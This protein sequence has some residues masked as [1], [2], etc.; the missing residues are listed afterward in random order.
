[1]TI[2]GQ[3]APDL[4]PEAYRTL[5]LERS[6]SL[7]DHDPGTRARALIAM[8]SRYVPRSPA[9]RVLCVGC[10]NARELDHLA[11]AGYPGAT[12]IDLHSA[13]PRVLVMDMHATS[14][15]DASFDVVYASHAL[16]HALDP[17]RAAAEFL[18]VVR[19]GGWIVIEVPVRYGRRGADLWDFGSPSVVASLFPGAAVLWSDVAP[20]IG[21]EKQLAARLIL[22][23]RANDAE[24]AS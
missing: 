5:Q 10:R 13:D 2:T 11:A 23:A 20:Q 3:T 9:P 12:G 19:G 18:R 4:T 21:A 15:E 16:E 1:M 6:L 24:G 14:F 17:R 7:K 8:M 22:R